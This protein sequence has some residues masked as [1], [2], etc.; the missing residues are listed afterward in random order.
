MKYSKQ[1]ILTTAALSVVGAIGF[2]YSQT[3]TDTV[4]PPATSGPTTDARAPDTTTPANQGATTQPA[5][6]QSSGSTMD[7]GSTAASS[8]ATS[9]TPSSDNAKM[10]TEQVARVDRN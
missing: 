4:P 6:P 7:S 10:G 5:S 1:L 2:A 3:G 8:G 9:S